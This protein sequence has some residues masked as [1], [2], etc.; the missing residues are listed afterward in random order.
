M[1]VP[2]DEEE[3][4]LLQK[5][6]FPRDSLVGTYEGVLV[7]I[8]P[9]LDHVVPYRGRSAG[10]KS[11]C[12]FANSSAPGTFLYAAWFVGGSPTP[13]LHAGHNLEFPLKQ[14]PGY[15]KY[16]EFVAGYVPLPKVMAD[17]CL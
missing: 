5:A 4:W 1:V 17:F 16:P 14:G 3:E 13:D 7:L 6:V 8:D 9:L 15:S 11:S 10:M 12:N 2:L